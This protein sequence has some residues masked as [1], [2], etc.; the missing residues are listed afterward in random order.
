[1]ES[2][3]NCPKDLHKNAPYQFICLNEKCDNE[4]RFGCLNRCFLSRHFIDHHPNILLIDDIFDDQCD[5]IHN[6][7]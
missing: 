6:W 2:S 5:S 4:N 3:F 1:M 7:P